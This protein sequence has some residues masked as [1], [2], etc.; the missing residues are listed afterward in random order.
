MN[1]NE[2]KLKDISKE[3][4]I[5]YVDELKEEK[6][7]PTRWEDLE[8]VKGYYIGET[9]DVSL[10]IGRL[11]ADYARNVFHTKEQAEASLAMAQL[12]QLMAVYNDGWV[13]NW[14]D[15]NHAKY[16]IHFVGDRI[17]M[18]YSWTLQRFLAF[19]TE[20]LRDKFL[21]NFEDLIRIAQPLL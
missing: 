18:D 12:S 3:T 13:P 10:K 19:K 7:L 11:S 4:L 5:K 21:E 9:S 15:G 16:A 14:E 2:M 6:E 17:I 1:I 8:E 20:E